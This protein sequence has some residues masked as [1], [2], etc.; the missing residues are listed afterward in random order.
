MTGDGFPARGHVEAEAAIELLQV[1]VGMELEGGYRLLP[2][3]M[4]EPHYDPAAQTETAA[5]WQHRNPSEDPDAVRAQ[6]EP[7]GGDGCFVGVAENVCGSV[8][9]A[10]MVQIG[11][12]PLLDDE[13]LMANPL[14]QRQ[15][16]GGGGLYD[17]VSSIHRLSTHAL[18]THG[19]STLELGL[20]RRLGG[21]W[22]IACPVGNYDSTMY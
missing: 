14:G 4:L 15:I 7:P 8:V 3:E 6:K 5:G 17:A 20:G 16:G 2:G 10:V 13:N 9:E 12:D 21:V 19:P 1:G 18:S 22:S 11:R